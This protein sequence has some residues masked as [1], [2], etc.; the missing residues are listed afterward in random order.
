[1]ASCSAGPHIQEAANTNNLK[2][3]QKETWHD[4]YSKQEG[5]EGNM[6]GVLHLRASCQ[7]LVEDMICVD[8]QS[9]STQ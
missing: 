1:M 2:K 3:A 7:C 5:A 6:A 4:G 8:L 9:P